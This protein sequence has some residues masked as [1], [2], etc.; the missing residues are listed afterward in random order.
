MT[1]INADLQLV[2]STEYLFIGATGCYESL[3]FFLNHYG[4]QRNVPKGL[5]W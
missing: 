4:I 1:E 5:I 3:F 2:Q